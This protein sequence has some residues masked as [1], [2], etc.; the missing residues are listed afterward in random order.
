MKFQRM[1]ILQIIKIKKEIINLKKMR[2][3]QMMKVTQEKTKDIKNIE[4]MKNIH[5]IQP[6]KS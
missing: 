3:V 1:M 2:T 5:L 6:I 4:S